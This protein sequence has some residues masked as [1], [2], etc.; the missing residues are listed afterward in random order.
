MVYESTGTNQWIHESYLG[1]VTTLE[2]AKAIDYAINR[3]QT[4]LIQLS[5]GTGIPK[6]DLL[7]MFKGIWNRKEVEIL[8]FDGKGVD[9]SIVKS[10]RFDYEVPGYEDML[11]E[12]RDWMEDHGDLYDAIYNG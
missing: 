11:L 8:P 4:G 9:K 2:L 12:Q 7:G 10:D 5:N 6:Y 3:N 1:G